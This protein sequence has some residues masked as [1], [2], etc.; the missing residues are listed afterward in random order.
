M[1]AG[2]PLD[3]AAGN[4]RAPGTAMPPGRPGGIG[5]GGEAPSAERD[6]DFL[7]QVVGVLH[8]GLHATRELH[9]P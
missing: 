6:G 9:V 7:E 1:V 8:A 2:S 5:C 4:L 3:I